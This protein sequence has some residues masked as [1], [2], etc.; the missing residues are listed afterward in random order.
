[1]NNPI[2]VNE[3]V[4]FDDMTPDDIVKAKI[5][6]L[7]ASGAVTGEHAVLQHRIHSDSWKM[8]YRA[9]FDVVSFCEPEHSWGPFTDALFGG[10]LMYGELPDEEWWKEH[11]GID[12]WSSSLA[13]NIADEI[14]VS[15]A[16]VVVENN[17]VASGIENCSTLILH[18]KTLAE[19]GVADALEQL[20]AEIGKRQTEVHRETGVTLPSVQVFIHEGDLETLE[21]FGR[22]L[23]PLRPV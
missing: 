4:L 1:M 16:S 9:I 19:T 10:E 20:V 18:K 7:I 5:V 2:P 23:V 6:D 21:V 13:G 14:V 12:D 17:R 3:Y 15:G 22:P 11:L 8:T